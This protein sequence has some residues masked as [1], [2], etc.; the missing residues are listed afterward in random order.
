L[1][2]EEARLRGRRERVITA[3][4]SRA[5][6]A[7]NKG[8]NGGASSA[9]SGRKKKLRTPSAGRL[10]ST[11]D[12]KKKNGAGHF[13]TR[14]RATKDRRGKLRKSS[15]FTTA[16]RKRARGKKRKLR[17]DALTSTTWS[18]RKKNHKITSQRTE[19]DWDSNKALALRKVA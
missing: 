3:L 17:K 1:P 15:S 16:T 12:Q 2:K 13:K 4:E 8:E 11:E 9:P 5:K 6:K 14:K 19:K 7:S 18:R 10:S